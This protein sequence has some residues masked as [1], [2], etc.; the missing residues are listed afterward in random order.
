MT[1]SIMLKKSKA[2]ALRIVRLVAFGGRRTLPNQPSA[3]R[4][5]TEV[6]LGGTTWSG[7]NIE[8]KDRNAKKN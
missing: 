6:S 8:E 1:E 2:F 3:D 4:P 7:W 5:D